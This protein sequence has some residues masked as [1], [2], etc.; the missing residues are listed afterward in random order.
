[1]LIATGDN[2]HSGAAILAARAGKDIYCE[3]P[4]SVCINESRAV[5]DTMKRLGRIFQ[6]GTQRRS[7]ANFI[8]AVELARSG[9]LG[10]LK[11]VQAEEAGGWQN[12]NYEVLPEEPEPPKE[13]FDWNRWLGPAAW[14]P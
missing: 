13:V 6:C 1:V 8:F 3:K 10:E 2:W 9:K 14:R 12:F 4:L 11:E 7:I 5:A